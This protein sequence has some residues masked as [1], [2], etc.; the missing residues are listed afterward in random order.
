MNETSKVTNYFNGSV[1]LITPKVY[2]DGR[3]NFIEAYNYKYYKLKYKIIDKFVQDNISFSKKKSTIRGMHL[4]KAP[5]EQSKLIFVIQGSIMDVFVDLRKN[6][7]TFGKHYS[8]ILKSNKKQF[9]YIKK[10]FA[11]GFKTLE[12]NTKV[13]YKVSNYYSSKHELTLSYLD[14]TINIDWKIKNKIPYLSDKDQTGYNLD[15]I[16]EYL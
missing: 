7:K 14:K 11:H 13:F 9:L 1:K 16:K 6:S 5:Y 4:Q 15:K 3:G 12:D 10:G 2:K 8:V